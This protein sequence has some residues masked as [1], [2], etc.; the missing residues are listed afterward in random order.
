MLADP[1]TDS[2]DSL[3]ERKLEWAEAEEA[4]RAAAAQADVPA[5]MHKP[6]TS[7]HIIS[8]VSL[9]VNDIIAL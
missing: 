9:V 4:K 3:L 7:Y 8:F 2:C 5:G 1:L 6:S